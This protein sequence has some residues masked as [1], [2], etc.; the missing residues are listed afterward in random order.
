MNQ[1]PDPQKP[2]PPGQ[3]PKPEPTP[4]TEKWDASV[5]PWCNVFHS[6]P[7]QIHPPCVAIG[8]VIHMEVV[9]SYSESFIRE[10]V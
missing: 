4:V 9:D 6:E 7:M 1:W 5:G 3:P 2:A 10:R 8:D